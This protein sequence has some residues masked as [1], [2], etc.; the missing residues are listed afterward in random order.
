MCL[1]GRQ[2]KLVQFIRAPRIYGDETI[3]CIVVSRK[4]VSGEITKQLSSYLK[5]SN[6][7]NTL[8]TSKVFKSVYE[9]KL[10][11]WKLFNSSNEYNTE[12]SYR[13][14]GTYCKDR[15]T[16]I[17]QIVA[18]FKLWPSIFSICWQTSHFEYILYI[19]F[20][21]WQPFLKVWMTYTM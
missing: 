3:V 2:G 10:W 21:K 4:D 14:N 18:S 7:L 5:S 12:I 6:L 11:W 13:S 16:L 8:R 15:D 1:P 19:H 9:V 17:F 20:L